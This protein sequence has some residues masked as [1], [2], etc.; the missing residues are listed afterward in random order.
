MNGLIITTILGGHIMG[1][2]LRQQMPLPILS[3][4]HRGYEGDGLFSNIFLDGLIKTANLLVDPSL[5]RGEAVKTCRLIRDDIEI[6][7]GDL[8]K[9][10]DLLASTVSLVQEKLF[11]KE[12]FCTHLTQELQKEKERL[13]QLMVSKQRLESQKNTLN[14][15]LGSYRKSID[16]VK[17]RSKRNEVAGG[18]SALL[19]V[20]SGIMA[21]AT[22]GITSPIFLGAASGATGVAISKTEKISLEKK[23][24][25][26]VQNIE[27]ICYHILVVNKQI[28]NSTQK[29]QNLTQLIAKLKRKISQNDLSIKKQG[30]KLTDAQNSCLMQKLLKNRCNS[31]QDDLD[32]VQELI[33]EGGLDLDVWFQSVMVYAMLIENHRRNYGTNIT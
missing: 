11:I 33:Q 21:I 19:L 28:E 4:S 24:K 23:Q 26:L 2:E 7:K 3:C 18:L 14:S 27:Y 32:M 12:R 10:L 8:N 5:S 20:V 29:I 1:V 9:S 17:E 13:N 15:Q 25:H 22:G 31:L 6:I 30:R 16:L